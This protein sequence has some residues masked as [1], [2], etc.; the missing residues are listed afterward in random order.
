MAML[1]DSRKRKR[2]RTVFKGKLFVGDTVEVRSEEDGFQ[3]SWHSGT[4]I[5]CYSQGR[6]IKYDNILRDNG[7]EKFEEDVHVSPVLDG[8]VSAN[9]NNCTDRGFIRP[10]PPHVDFNQWCLPYGMCVDVNYREAWWEGV[11][12]DHDDGSNTRRIF[13]PDLGDELETEFDMLRISQVWNEVTENWQR[14]G[15]WLFLEV[16]EEYEQEGYLGVSVKQIW[17]DLRD[18]IGFKKIK[19]WT[20]MMRDL[21][22]GLVLEVIN[23]NLNIILK[24]VFQALECSGGLFQETNGGLEL[25][26]TAVGVDIR[27]KADLA[28]SLAIV[29]F[30][31]SLCSDMLVDQEKSATD[32]FISTL[33][34]DRSDVNILADSHGKAVCLVAEALTVLP[35][36]QDG[37]SSINSMTI[38]EEVSTISSN[39]I[40]GKPKCSTR[41]K[42][43]N[44]LPVGPD[45]LPGAAFCPEAITEYENR[46]MNNKRLKNYISVAKNLRKHLSYLGWKIDSWRD[47]RTLRL[48]YTS[49]D[50]KCYYSL[51]QV[52]QYMRGSTTERIS[53]ITDKQRSLLVLPDDPSSTLLLEQQEENQDPDFSPQT[54]VSPQSDVLREKPK[55]CP[56]A[57][58]DYY[59]HGLEKKSKTSVL[60]SKARMHL[61][62]VGWKIWYSYPRG[63]RELRYTSPRGRVYCSLRS[64]CKCCMAEGF[65]ESVA[66]CCEPIQSICA[67]EEDEGQLASDKSSSA[68]SNAPSRR[69]SRESSCISESAKLPELGKEKV[70]RIRKICG[71]RKDDFLH[72]ASQS[73]RTQPNLLAIKDGSAIGLIGDGKLNAEDQNASLSKL[74]RRKVSGALIKL[75][76]D[77]E[78]SH[79]T[80]VLRSRK[81]VQ[82][83]VPSSSSHQTPR[84]ILS[85]LID[86]NVVLPREKVHYRSIKKNKPMA[87]GRITRDGIKCSCCQKVFTLAG[88][89]VHAGSKYHR[90]AASIFLED[91][92]MFQMVNGSAHHAV[93]EFVR[94]RNSETTMNILLMT[95][96][97]LAI[98]VSIN[99]DHVGCVRNRDADKLKISPEENWFCCKKCEQIS[100]GLH[101]ILGKPI[102]LGMD[103]LT[104]TLLKPMTSDS[105]DI[106]DFTEIYSKLNIALDVMHECFEPVKESR[107]RRDLVEDVI[108]SRGSELNR[109]NFRG[110]YTVLLERN[111]EMIT[112]A[113]VRIHGEKAAEIPLI[114]TR[115]PYRRLGMCRILMNELEKKLMELGVERLILPAVPSVLNTWTTSFLFTK[116]T[117]SERLQFL[118]YTFL[119]FQGTV[120]CQ[121]LLTKIP[122]A[123]TSPAR[124]SKSKSCGLDYGSGDLD[125]SSVVS[126]VYQPEQIDESGIV[127]QGLV[128]YV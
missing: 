95:A 62:A 114:G 36:N 93:V 91:G 3:G 92:R 46:T 56:Q 115:F 45:I 88:F 127:E 70:Q 96:F 82:E 77:L 86:N 123:E 24:E 32:E 126:E 27:P 98:S 17:Y 128:V 90:P 85:W 103:N 4:V 65:S 1:A 44:W 40:D 61:L 69:G 120:M 13:F 20:C 25:A 106:E 53:S 37:T 60:R 110:F 8:I 43:A 29:P 33:N 111:D 112:V 117:D 109:L 30:E 28:N 107:T 52:C 23:E 101:E 63:K 38:S 2:K 116:M 50:G 6:R 7:S 125:V 105:Q 49:P 14:R 104:W 26:R 66:S 87:E 79:P 21:W 5:A 99:V 11:I 119:D 16:I 83:V 58:V 15:T 64:A 113:T 34:V 18:K 54:V 67:I 118:H 122:P 68:A 39:K 55:F 81:R 51:C 35:S 59:M 12:F 94:K 72:L 19:E 48:R 31:N 42:T 80:R 75:R 100:L 74:K 10:L 108:F 71:N 78:S 41:R 121:K 97:S 89:E 102:P 47:G 57:V 84:T 73:L 22:K 9:E 76:D 124:G